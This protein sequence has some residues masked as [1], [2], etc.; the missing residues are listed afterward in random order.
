MAFAALVSW[1]NENSGAIQALLT[2]VLVIVTTVYVVL[3]GRLARES[4]A[5]RE[6]QTRP[7]V[8]AAAQLDPRWWRMVNLVVENLGNGP[9]FD[10]RFHLQGD[11]PTG[12]DQKLSE[13]EFLKKGFNYIGPREKIAFLLTY[14]AGDVAEDAPDPIT[15]RVSYRSHDGSEYV[16]DCIIDLSE[17]AGDRRVGSHPMHQV[18]D[19]LKDIARSLSRMERR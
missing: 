4:R 10:V 3:T 5:M 6:A 16:D 13:S 15:I 19:Q 14:S 9:A 7:H 2:A 18:A 8:R 1:L 17:F 11:M 12:D